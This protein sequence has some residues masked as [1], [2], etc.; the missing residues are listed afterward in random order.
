MQK[1][2][3]NKK[4]IKLISSVRQKKKQQKSC[5]LIIPLIHLPTPTLL[6]D[7]S[8][9]FSFSILF[10]NYLGCF[11]VVF[12]VY[13]HGCVVFDQLLTCLNRKHFALNTKKYI[14]AAA[15][16]LMQFLY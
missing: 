15:Y 5:C 2:E 4:F 3:Q 7:D 13:L 10:Y 8:T 16:G 12:N 6:L 1:K 11:F 9:K 14:T